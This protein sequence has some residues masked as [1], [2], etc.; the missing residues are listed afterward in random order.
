MEV[1]LF[2]VIK[3]KQKKKKKKLLKYNKRISDL[4]FILMRAN[5]EAIRYYIQKCKT[6]TCSSHLEEMYVCRNPALDFGALWV[7]GSF[8][9]LYHPHR[10][11]IN[12]TKPLSFGVFRRRVTLWVNFPGGCG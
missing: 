8:F 5:S 10:T 12:Q 6:C 9:S 4:I 1:W 11:S 3:V 7:F 2:A